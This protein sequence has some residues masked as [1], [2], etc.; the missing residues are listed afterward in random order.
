[1][2]IYVNTDCFDAQIGQTDEKA[3]FTKIGSHN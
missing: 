3:C 1:M 2:L